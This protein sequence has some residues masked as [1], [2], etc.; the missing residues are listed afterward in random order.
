VPDDVDDLLER[1]AEIEADDL[2]ALRLRRI[3]AD[4]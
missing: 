1:D 4:T 3:H 2:Y